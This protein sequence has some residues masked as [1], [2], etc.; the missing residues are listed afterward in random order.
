MTARISDPEELKELLGIPFTPEQTAC[1]TAPPAPQVVVAGAGS[2]KTTVMAARVV[3]LV[4]TG[5]VAPEEVLGLTF[6]NKA[7]GELAERVRTALVRAGVTDPDTIDPDNP[8]GEPRISTYHAFAGRLLDDHGLRIGL[9]PTA[10]LLAD[11]TR[12]Q[13]AARVLREAPGPY[14]ALTRSFPTLVS[15]LLALDAELSEHLVEP[16]RLAAYDAELLRALDGTRLGNAELRKVPEAVAA[17]RELLDLTV[18]YRAAKRS[19]ELLDFGDQIALSAELALTRP[20]TGRILR[21]EF[22]VVLLDEYQDTSVAQ[23]LLL[24]GLFG[25]AARPGA[26]EPAPTGHAVTAVGDPCQAIYG[27][28][29]ASVA[30]LDD[31]PDHFPHR[32]GTP[33]TRY[34]LSENRRSG[35]RLL[36]LANGLAAPLRARHEGVEALRP[37]PGAEHDGTVRIALLPTHQEEIAWIADSIA[38]LVRTGTA[39]GE[40]AVLCRTAADF[41]EIQGALVARDIPVEVVGLSGLLHLPEVADLVAVCEVLQDPGANASLVRLLTGP[42]WRIGARDLALLGRRARLLVHRQGDDADPADADERLAAAVEGTDPAEVISLAD[43][44]DTFLDSSGGVGPGGPGGT[45]GT[46][47]GLPFS[48]EARVRF[49]HLAAELRELRRA[50]GDPLMDV[51]HRVLGATGLDVELSASP[52]ALAARRRETLANFLDTAAAF[53]GL[54]GEATLLAFLGFLRTAARYEKGL[55][56]ALPGGENTVKVLTAHKSK[57]LEWDVVAVPGLVAGQFPNDRGREAWTSHPQ[58]LPHALRGDADTLPS[59]PAWDS[60]G[61]KAFKDGMKDHQ[62]TEELRL[63]YVTFTRPR[64]LLLGS[65]HWWGPVQKRRRGPSAFLTALYDHCA[66]GHGEIEAWADEPAEG[67]ENPTLAETGPDHAWPLPLDP[68]SLA[69]RR[70]AA[71]TVRAYLDREADAEPAPDRAGGPGPE[72]GSELFPEGLDDAEAPDEFDEPGAPDAPDGEWAGPP[73]YPD[74]DPYEDDDPYGVSVSVSAAVAAPPSAAPA[75]PGAVLPH[76]PTGPPPPA[77]PEDGLAPEE[78][79]TIASWDRDL[80]ALA[81][82][83]RRTRAAVRDVNLPAS[84]TASQLI[85]LA[86]DPDGFARELAR[87]MPRR[88]QPAARRGIRFHAWVESRFEEL[89]LPL[90]GPDELPGGDPADAAD[91]PDIADEQDLAELK[92]AFARTPYAGRTPYRVESPFQITLAGRVIRGRIDAVYRTPAA[93]GA[94]ARYEIVDWKT[95]RTGTADPLQLA[96]YRLAWAEQ[97]GLAPEDVGAAFVFVRSGEVARPSALP[98]RAELERL[99][100][101]EHDEHDGG[102]EGGR[103]GGREDGHLTGP[104]AG[105]NA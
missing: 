50:L 16:A 3:W 67:E 102:D 1:I 88:P 63:G 73:P 84:L 5:Q 27:W 39:P 80:D 46:D 25:R 20:E 21:D 23:R 71:E 38:H 54:D 78:R 62:H 36:R 82:E 14:P 6:T 96:I 65:G 69:R 51:L 48:A 94:P 70:R 99:L 13:L 34:A 95:G 52:H 9:E 24:S 77:D 4:G 29:G 68:V 55:D 103:G 66:A 32:D 37:A 22:K 74:V 11:A 30:N 89:P 60:K 43:A 2:G 101:D 44:L 45:G 79:R 56:N 59:V 53:A 85:R 81:G 57:G 35:G 28:R 97:H 18:R 31:F 33:A 8:P 100:R 76:Q 17:R 41:P 58:V 83:L 92:E 87:P 75:P 104:A 15:D 64:S 72:P 19:R 105:G 90:L 91:A 86:A 47:E 42:R 10:R 26:A 98:G 40:I 12:Y 93:G 7:A 49:A 61:L